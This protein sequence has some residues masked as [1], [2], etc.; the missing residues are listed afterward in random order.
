[1]TIVRFPGA[2]P[3]PPDPSASELAEAIKRAALEIS[4]AM[5]ILSEDTLAESKR[6]VMA[7]KLLVAS[8]ALRDALQHYKDGLGEALHDLMHGETDNRSTGD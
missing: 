3:R 2:G 1:M 6:M 5:V 7:D 4:S 8:T